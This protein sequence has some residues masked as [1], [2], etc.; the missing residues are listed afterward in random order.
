MEVSV[1]PARPGVC[2]LGSWLGTVQSSAGRTGCERTEGGVRPSALD[3]Q[4]GQAESSCPRVGGHQPVSTA[5][6]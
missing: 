6:V 3:M 2:L 4:A 5:R 1:V